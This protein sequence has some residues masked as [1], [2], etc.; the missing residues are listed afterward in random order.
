MKK[1]VVLYVVIFLISIFNLCARD[2]LSTGKALNIPCK[3]YGLSFGNSYEFNGIRINFADNNVKKINGINVTFWLSKYNNRDAVVNGISF[4]IIPTASRMGLINIGVLGVG[5]SNNN[6]NGFSFGGLG[7][8]SGGN[9]NGLSIGGLLIMADGDSSRI[10]GISI[11]GLGLGAKKTINGIG[12]AG[13]IVGTDGDIN[14]MTTS[15]IYISCEKNYRGI[16]FTGYLK[17]Y[18]Y[19]GVAIVGYSRTSQLFGLSVALYNRTDELHG[20]QIGLLNYAGN[21]PKGLKYLP[22]LNLHF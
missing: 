4:G 18:K 2:T 20:V 15:L 11:A 9:V 16:A 17:S 22:A 10:S 5:T 13:L 19:S 6:L 3:K 7:I 14:G 21:N 1:T 12:V 8:G